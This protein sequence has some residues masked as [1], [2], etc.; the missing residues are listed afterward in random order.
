LLRHLGGQRMGVAVETGI[1]GDECHLDHVEHAFR[2]DRAL[3]DQ[4]SRPRS[5]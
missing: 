1:I 5:G 3:F 4:A 2:D